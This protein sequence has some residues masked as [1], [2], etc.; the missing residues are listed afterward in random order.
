[1]TRYQVHALGFPAHIIKATDADTAQA[2]YARL[3]PKAKEVS[4][5]DIGVLVIAEPARRSGFCRNAILDLLAKEGAKTSAVIMQKLQLSQGGTWAALRGLIDQGKVRRVRMP[6]A[7]VT[8][9]Y[10]VI[11]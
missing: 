10:E 9:V 2:R 11:T 7:G 5:I 3:Y 1:M 6:D 8:Y 4:C